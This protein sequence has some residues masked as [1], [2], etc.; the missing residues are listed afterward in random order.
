VAAQR[1]F[2]R[3]KKNLIQWEVYLFKSVS[4]FAFTGIHKKQVNAGKFSSNKQHIHV[5]KPLKMKILR[6][7]P[8]KPR[9]NIYY[10]IPIK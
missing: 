7:L 1:N 3:S 9:L 2:S 4:P 6:F 10:L 8:K 5:Y